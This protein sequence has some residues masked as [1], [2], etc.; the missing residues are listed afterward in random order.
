MAIAVIKKKTA[1]ILN[2][3][4]LIASFK[5]NPESIISSSFLPVTGG[6]SF[7]KN[8][9]N[10]MPIITIQNKTK[11]PSRHPCS[12]TKGV[13]YLF[14]KKAPSPAEVKQMPRAIPLFLSNH[15]LTTLVNPIPVDGNAKND[16][17]INK[18]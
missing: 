10:G 2:S 3:R 8:Q 14:V 18:R 7:T 12:A 13:K 1:R 16:I 11:N 15:A 9:T 6:T 17:T 4:V 5:V